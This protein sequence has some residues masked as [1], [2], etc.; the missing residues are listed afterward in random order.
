MAE[1]PAT[2]PSSPLSPLS[3]TLPPGNNSTLLSWHAAGM[4]K[5]LQEESNKLEKERN[6]LEKERS[7]FELMKS[8]IATIHFPSKIK[9]NIGGQV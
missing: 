5:I 2:V 1:S 8:R 3:I 6:Q 9:L 4:T 7:T